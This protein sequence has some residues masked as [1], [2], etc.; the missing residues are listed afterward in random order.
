MNKENQMT[1][2]IE[3]YLYLSFGDTTDHCSFDQIDISV[4]HIPFKI[5]SRP[6]VTV[7]FMS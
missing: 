6:Q 3:K 7:L 4:V 2:Q 1:Y 5:F